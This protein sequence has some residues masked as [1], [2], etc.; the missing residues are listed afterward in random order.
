MKLSDKQRSMI[1]TAFVAAFE[2]DL[3]I[4]E[5]KRRSLCCA[6]DALAAC[7][8]IVGKRKASA[9][10][11]FFYESLGCVGWTDAEYH[12]LQEDYFLDKIAAMETL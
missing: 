6:P 8:R 12:A 1:A 3:G 11:T 7:A 2:H 9:L 4:V 10:Q 5:C